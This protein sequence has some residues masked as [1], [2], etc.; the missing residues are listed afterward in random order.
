MSR[1]KLQEKKLIMYFDKIKVDSRHLKL[2]QNFSN[3]LVGNL[4]W[5]CSVSAQ[6]KSFWRDLFDY[7]MK[8][9][10]YFFLDDSW[11]K[12]D[13]VYTSRGFNLLCFLIKMADK[14]DWDKLKAAF[15][16]TIKEGNE[17]SVVIR[18]AYAFTMARIYTLDQE[19]LYS[20]LSNVFYGADEDVIIDVFVSY[21]KKSIYDSRFYEELQSNWILSF[22]VSLQDLNERT[23]I[24]IISYLSFLVALFIKGKISEKA[25]D[26]VLSDFKELNIVYG[27]IL[28]LKEQADKLNEDEVKRI[29]TV[30]TKIKGAKGLCFDPLVILLLDMMKTSSL[31]KKYIWKDVL[32]LAE[33]GFTD[34]YLDDVKKYFC[35]EPFLTNEEKIIF[36]KSVLK[37]GKVGELQNEVIEQIFDSVDWSKDKDSFYTLITIIQKQNTELSSQL[38]EQFKSKY[39]KSDDDSVS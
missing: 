1:N 21:N 33:N 2:V 12:S 27:G 37:K 13:S 35:D 31:L 9:K 6:F 8:N 25:L 26:E 32:A 23:R 11:V 14:D 17:D 20:I 7:S 15:H 4:S 19:Y 34:T 22:I 16:E 30:L 39:E 29:K 36:L 3:C 18:A 10:K 24:D 28:K 38:M 5:M